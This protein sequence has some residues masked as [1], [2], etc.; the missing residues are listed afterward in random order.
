MVGNADPLAELRDIHLPPPVD[1]AALAPG[2]WILIALSLAA[3]VLGTLWL[4]RRHLNRA[5]RREA[6]SALDAALLRWTES[7]AGG[8]AD[9]PGLTYLHEQNRL[10]K[11]VAMRSFGRAAV[12]PLHGREWAEFLD[13]QWPRPDARFR[14][15]R[16]DDM[17]YAPNPEEADVRA[18]HT[19]ARDW[20]LQ[21][22]EGRR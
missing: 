14:L 12:A 5:Y 13:R 11:R 15:W 8:M 18:L 20:L 7:G 3:L 22:R 6:V 17:P 9:G 16:I 21:H 2:W 4:V 1:A 10:L 19:L